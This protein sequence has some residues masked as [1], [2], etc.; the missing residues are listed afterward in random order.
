MT[1]EAKTIVGV[2]VAVQSRNLGL[3]QKAVLQTMTKCR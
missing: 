2:M 3:L 1:E